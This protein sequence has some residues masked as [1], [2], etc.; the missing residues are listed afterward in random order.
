MTGRKRDIEVERKRRTL[1]LR[2]ALRTDKRLKRLRV[3]KRTASMNMTT[4]VNTMVTSFL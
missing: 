3:K 1:G 4:E 2:M